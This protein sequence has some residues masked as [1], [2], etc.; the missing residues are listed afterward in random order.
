MK[1]VNRPENRDR[2]KITHI[3]EGSDKVRFEERPSPNKLATFIWLKQRD[4]WKF[5][6]GESRI[7]SLSLHVDYDYIYLTHLSDQCIISSL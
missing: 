3:D 1:N 5:R 4:E 7:K 6:I 2:A